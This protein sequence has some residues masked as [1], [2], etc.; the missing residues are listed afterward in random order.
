MTIAAPIFT[1]ALQI[2]V[3]VRDL[4]A[5]VRRYTH[6]YGVGPWAILEFNP[7][8]VSDMV[9]DDAPASYAM[10]LAVANIGRLQIE[11]IEPLDDTSIYASISPN[12]GKASTTL[13]WPWTTTRAPSRRCA[14][15]ATASSWAATT[16]A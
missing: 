2:A 13:P 8:A 10:R 3:I 1:D 15:R 9:I 12:T 5:A 11:L 4:D 14:P 6:E 16:T 7:D